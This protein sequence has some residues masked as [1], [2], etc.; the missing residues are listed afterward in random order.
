MKT[1]NVSLPAG[2]KDECIAA[3][4]EIVHENSSSIVVII[5][6][7]I[8]QRFDEICDNKSVNTF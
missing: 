6:D 8:P 4:Y 2:L 1:W 3:G 5:P 7:P